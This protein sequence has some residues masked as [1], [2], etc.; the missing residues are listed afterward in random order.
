ML[1]RKKSR[2]EKKSFAIHESQNRKKKH[3]REI[4]PDQTLLQETFAMLRKTRLFYQIETKP[5]YIFCKKHEATATLV[6]EKSVKIPAVLYDLICK[7]PNPP[8][9]ASCYC[10][11][12][13][14][15]NTY[16]HIKHWERES[17][18]GVLQVSYQPQLHTSNGALN[19]L[20]ISCSLYAFASPIT[21]LCIRF[22]LFNYTSSFFSLEHTSDYTKR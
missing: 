13:Q 21:P 19:S 2:V 20:I 9:L 12:S 18:P 6:F 14:P 11:L 5:W 10:C 1:S 3:T 7:P 16:T 17:W 8:F 4:K 15:Q 22:F